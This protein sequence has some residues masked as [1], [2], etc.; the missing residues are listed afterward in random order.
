[1]IVQTIVDSEH[2]TTWCHHLVTNNNVLTANMIKHAHIHIL[3]RKVV[4]LSGIHAHLWQ[5][6]EYSPLLLHVSVCV[7]KCS[8]MFTYWQ[9]CWV[10][11]YMRVSVDTCMYTW[12][13]LLMPSGYHVWLYSRMHTYTNVIVAQIHIMRVANT[14]YWILSNTVQYCIRAWFKHCEYYHHT[15]MGVHCI[16]RMPLQCKLFSSCGIDEGIWCK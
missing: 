13:T 3:G 10:V 14:H 4:I 12:W 11:D 1:M 8:M 2:Y 16:P 15:Y 6:C 5:Y 7:H 9:S